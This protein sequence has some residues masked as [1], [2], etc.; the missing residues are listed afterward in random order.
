[1]AISETSNTPS[2]AA[3]TG[4]NTTTGDG[5]WGQCDGGRGV[6]GV[7]NSGTGV[8]AH[9]TSG[10]GVVGVNNEEGTGVWGETKK[11]RGVVGIVKTDGDGTWGECDSGRGVVGVS[12]TG[13]GVWGETT[14]GRGVVGVSKTGSGVWGETTNGRA[15]VGVSA[16]DVGVFGKGGRLAG[17]FEGNVD[18]SGN[19]T[20]QGVSIQAWLQ[21][22]IVLEREVVA[23][24]QQLASHSQPSGGSSGGSA[25]IAFISASVQLVPGQTARLL[26]ISGYGFQPAEKVGFR[27]TTRVTGQNVSTDDSQQ[28]TANSLGQIEQKVS[29]LGDPRN[30]P[31]FEVQATGLSSGKKSNVASAGW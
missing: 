9:T 8:W 20:I 17:Q 13:S 28:T 3:V 5:V 6:V 15:V 18:I 14:N 1:M 10:R 16:T 31:T 7:S 11:G 22:I 12:K 4:I 26:V 25:A 23:L 21:R 30:P 19:L 29:V 27:I 2:Q 24:R